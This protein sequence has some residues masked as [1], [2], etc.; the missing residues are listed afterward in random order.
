[1]Y[2]VLIEKTFSSAHFLRQYKGKDEP[3][4][5]HNW[6]VQVKF[7]GAKLVQPEEY[8][9]DFV[10]AQEIL[11]K[12][13]GKIDYKN[14]NEVPPFDQGG[15]PVCSDGRSL[16]LIGV[17]SANGAGLDFD[18]P[19]VSTTPSTTPTIARA[20]TTAASGQKYWRPNGR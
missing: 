2:E 8:L 16:Q 18:D 1:M 19:R 12:I 20:T 5:G 7:A 4:H 10:E 13:I 17:F 11:G 6:R 3:L 15:L 9:I 14:I